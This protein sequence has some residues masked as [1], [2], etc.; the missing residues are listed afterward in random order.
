MSV[1]R[2]ARDAVACFLALV[3]IAGLAQANCRPAP[4]DV[5]R[6]VEVRAGFH[7]VEGPLADFDP[8]HPSVDLSMPG[9]LSDRLPGKPPLLIIVHGG[10]GPGAAEREMARR[11]NARGVATL[12]FD[13]FAM[14]GFQYRGTPLFLTGVTNESR[15]R[16]IFKVSLGAYSWAK[17]QEG[18]DVSR[19]F[20]HGLSNGGSV[21]FNM[22]AVVGAD[23]V[24][25]VFAEGLSPTGIG[26]PDHVK[27]PVKLV[28]GKLD[29]YGGKRE[30]DWMHTRSDPCGFNRPSPLAAPGTT[31]FCSGLANPEAMTPSPQAWGEAARGRGQPIEFWF[32]EEAAHGL[33]A[34]PLVKGMRVYGTGPAAQARYGW[35]GASTEAAARFTED[36]I[37][38]IKA[39]Y[40]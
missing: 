37:Q 15:Q 3:P 10:N 21:A 6:L 32:Y 22:A 14:N 31:R 7:R 40:P 36:M 16:M 29:N 24:R 26:M 27:V 9:F 38:A 35:T 18:I 30:D 33:L 34:G 17:R 2:S 5:A 28:F 19:M 12:L 13:A 23:R 20:V 11:M 8:C 4:P 39:T 1:R 25:M